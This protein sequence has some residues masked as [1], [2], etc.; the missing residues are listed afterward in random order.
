MDC[1]KTNAVSHNLE[2]GYVPAIDGMRAL[3]ISI[4]IASHFG[5]ERIFPGGF[6]VTLFFFISGFLITSLMIQEHTKTG[7]ISITSFYIRRFLRLAPALMVSIATVSTIFF[8]MFGF[9][10]IP[11]I[12]AA[13]FYYM[14]FYVILGGS[15]PLPLGPLWSLAVEEHYYLIFPIIFANAWKNRERFLIALVA[16]IVAVLLWRCLLVFSWHVS[17]D[18]TYLATD[19]RI[20]SILYGAILAATPK[21]DLALLIKYLKS[22]IVIIVSLVVLLFTFIYRD[23]AFRET[24]RYSLQGVAL[25]PLFY[26]TLFSG[27]LL[28]VRNVLETKLLVWIGK[29]SY[30]LYLWHMPVLFFSEKILPDAQG[31]AAFVLKV[32]ITIALSAGSF[33]VVERHFQNMRNNFRVTTQRSQF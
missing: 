8:F 22:W 6:G 27:N 3:A 2:K 11:Q 28:F 32:V 19:T 18:R 26:A 14:N 31:I 4:V 21:T 9:V 7:R 17:T 24:F 23:G 15:A 5:A 33:Y 29:L 12:S 20:D 30:S 16:V 1:P 25:I 10:S 13:I